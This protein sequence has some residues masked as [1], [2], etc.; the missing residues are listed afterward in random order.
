[1]R[2][3]IES[4]VILM[5]F[6]VVFVIIYYYIYHRVAISYYR[7]SLKAV[8]SDVDAENLPDSRHRPER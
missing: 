2:N 3:S 8:R 4:L 7:N 5:I 1:M 6:W